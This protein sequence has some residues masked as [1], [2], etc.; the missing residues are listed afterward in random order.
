MDIIVF[1][2]PENEKMASRLAKEIQAEMGELS[3]RH[4]PDGESYVRV[5]SEVKNKTVFLYSP[6]NHI[7]PKF[8]T[9]YFLCGI[10]KSLGSKRII[11]VAPYLSYM[12][13]DKIFHPG[14]GITSVY[15][16][17]LISEMADEL[18]TID[19][20]LHRIKDLGEIYTIPTHVLQTADLMSEWI[21]KKVDRPIIIGP[22]EESEQ[23]VSKV[24]DNSNSAYVILSKTRLGDNKVEISIPNIE[25]YK[26]HT[27]VL[28]DDIISTGGTMI[29]TSKQLKKLGMKKPICICVHPLFSEGAYENLEKNDIKRIVTCNTI[30]HPSNDIDVLLL[31][32]SSIKKRNLK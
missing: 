16:A 6:L 4:F 20:H 5:L 17:S 26:G 24:A 13:Q 9:L 7:D 11:L 2:L 8:L 25:N 31:I 12:R 10:L 18:I 29:E 21:K 32:S 14:E 27:P 1:A 3:L 15:F 28:L 30:E 19:P 22:D 23:W